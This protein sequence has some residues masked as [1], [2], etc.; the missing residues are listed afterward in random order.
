MTLRL[1]FMS[2][3]SILLETNMTMWQI[4]QLLPTLNHGP[5]TC[6]LVPLGNRPLLKMFELLTCLQQICS[7]D[8]TDSFIGKTSSRSEWVWW[9]YPVFNVAAAKECWATC[10][11]H[12]QYS[13]QLVTSDAHGRLNESNSGCLTRRKTIYFW[14]GLGVSE[15]ACSVGK[16][17]DKN[18]ASFISLSSLGI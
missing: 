7:P 2:L 10:V 8:R 16:L 13:L 17:P 14:M 18:G 15:L 4:S 11:R 3:V 9:N 1:M 5:S 12:H 6:N